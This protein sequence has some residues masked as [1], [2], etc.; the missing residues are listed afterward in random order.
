MGWAEGELPLFSDPLEFDCEKLLTHRKVERATTDTLQP[1]ARLHRRELCAILA[2][3]LFSLGGMRYFKVNYHLGENL[4]WN[5]T[6]PNV[7]FKILQP[8]K[9]KACM[10]VGGVVKKSTSVATWKQRASFYSLVFVMLEMFSLFKKLKMIKI[11]YRHNTF[12]PNTQVYGCIKA[13]TVSSLTT[14]LL[15]TLNGIKDNFL[16][17]VNIHIHIHSPPSFPREGLYCCFSQVSNHCPHSAL[18]RSFYHCVFWIIWIFPIA[19][20]I[21]SKIKIEMK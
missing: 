5:D 4:G 20:V 7:C 18:G 2:L 17:S 3:S 12:C 8:K 21:Y 13:R 16:K 10:G 1:L 11:S 9:T 15:V 14:M 6:L 19:Y